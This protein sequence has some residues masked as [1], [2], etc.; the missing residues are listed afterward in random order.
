MAPDALRSAGLARLVR[1]DLG[2]VA[3]LI[4]STTRDQHTGVLALWETV[5][6]SRLFG[7]RPEFCLRVLVGRS[8]NIFLHSGVGTRNDLT[9]AKS[10]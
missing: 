4:A 2:D 8:P 6:A 7:A 1:R 5:R 9:S 3:T 10:W